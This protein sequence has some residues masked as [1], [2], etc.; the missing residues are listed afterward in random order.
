MASPTRTPDALAVCALAALSLMSGALGV[1]DTGLLT[2]I[3][4][5]TGATPFFW[6]NGY[7]HV[8]PATV[9]YA[10]GYLPLAA[11]AVGYR[12]AALAAVALLYRETK[13]LLAEPGGQHAGAA[14]LLAAS[15]MCA[16]HVIDSSL[17]ANLTWV[18]WSACL[19]AMAYLLTATT[20]PARLSWIGFSGV[21]VGLLT[22]PVGLLAV[23]ILLRAAAAHHARRRQYGALAAMVT[24]VHAAQA[25]GG[26]WTPV[27]SPTGRRLLSEL[28]GDYP[29]NVVIMVVALTTLGGLWAAAVRRRARG[30]WATGANRPEVRA[31]LA[32]LGVAATVLFLLAPDREPQGYE[33]RFVLVP[34]YCA[35]VAIATAVLERGRPSTRGLAIGV[36]AGLILMMTVISIHWDRRGPIVLWLQKYQFLA[37]AS[38]FRERC[39][40][41]QV[42]VFEDEPSAAVVLC[43]PQ[44][45]APG[46][47][48][49]VE[50]TPEK[51]EYSAGTSLAR[52]PS[53]DVPT[54]LF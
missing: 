41:G 33:P 3:N 43:R 49:I 34:A 25:W 2:Y 1:D 44:A 5:V 22:T 28:G 29:H 47:Y 13:R 23:P 36:F 42:M 48:P 24:V 50:F 21:A 53:I 18:N 52:R 11:Q 19:A 54:P 16:L 31:W 37:E 20:V 12:V 46:R 27:F 6:A 14:A 17:F 8:I 39:T 9:A 4:N 45:L 51:G 10:L 38:V 7:F 26:Q 40:D 35:L 30:E 15:I 32:Y